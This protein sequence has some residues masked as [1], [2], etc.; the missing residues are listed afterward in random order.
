VQLKRESF[1]MEVKRLNYGKNLTQV[2]I[3]KM[4]GVRQPQ[5][6]NWLSAKRFPNSTNLI[7]LSNLLDME[8]HEL[9]FKL[10]EIKDINS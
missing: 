9:L 6:S 7:K 8:P 10:Q 1:L 4:M 2:D 5:V 3:A